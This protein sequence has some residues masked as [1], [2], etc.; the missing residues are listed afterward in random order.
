MYQGVLQPLGMSIYMEGTHRLDLEDGR[1]LLLESII[2]LQPYEGKHVEVLGA[3][4]PTVE[5]GGQIMRI[6][7]VT[8][9]GES[10]A[11]S[12]S[13]G[14]GSSLSSESSAESSASLSTV[15][16][17]IPVSSS[18]S[19]VSS[20]SALPSSSSLAV[21][22][23]VSSTNYQASDELSAKAEAMSKAD[24]AISKWTQQYCSTPAGFCFPV[25]KNWYYNSFGATTSALWRVEVG[26]TAVNNLGEGPLIVLLLPGAATADGNVTVSGDAAT[27]QRAWTDN[28]HFEVRAPASLQ[29]A[30]KI[31]VDGIKPVQ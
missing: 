21:I 12:E 19:S 9:L 2:D 4:R 22:S 26:P 17:A 25:H 29:A 31:I 16:S 10:S 14:S 11:S 20:S 15:S 8:E 3:V 30:I 5:A 13:S 6:E 23:S 24:M 7:R 27:G 1:F 18:R 28:R